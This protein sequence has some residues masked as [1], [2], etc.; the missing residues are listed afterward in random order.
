MERLS[1]PVTQQDALK[2][3]GQLGTDPGEGSGSVNP[4]SREKTR[5]TAAKPEDTGQCWKKSLVQFCSVFLATL[6]DFVGLDCS[7]PD[8]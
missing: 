3:G 4:A 2:S 7:A 1:L 8:A 5:N 6:F